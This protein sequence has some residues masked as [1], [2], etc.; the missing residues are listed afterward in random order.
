M[1]DLY[2]RPYQTDYR[3]SVWN[4]GILPGLQT[5]ALF[6]LWGI[7][8]YGTG[9]LRHGK[10]DTQPGVVQSYIRATYRERAG[11]TSLLTAVQPR[12]RLYRQKHAIQRLLR[13][14]AKDLAHGAPQYQQ[15]RANQRGT[16]ASLS[17]SPHAPR[18]QSDLDSQ[19]PLGK[20]VTKPISGTEE[21][22]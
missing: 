10:P 2:D 14:R 13:S 3:N 21:V 16:K 5:T 19:P 18:A 22:K 4:C 12:F 6:R 7:Q 17:I 11:T 20:P 8:E 9:I 15:G 1:T